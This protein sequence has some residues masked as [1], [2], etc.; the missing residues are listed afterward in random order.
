MEPLSLVVV[1]FSGFII[2]VALAFGF[3]IYTL[4]NS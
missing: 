4:R 2:G 1:G 3:F